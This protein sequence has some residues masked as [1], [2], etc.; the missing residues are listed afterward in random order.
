MAILQLHKQS[1]PKP[2][3]TTDNPQT[4]VWK[5][6]QLHFKNMILLWCSVVTIS[7]RLNASFT[8]MSINKTVGE[9]SSKTSTKSV[10]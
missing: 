8:E 3:L 9:A 10:T 5:S 7:A 2:Y 1:E 6:L 4:S